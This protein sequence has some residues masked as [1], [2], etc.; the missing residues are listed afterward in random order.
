[1]I[2]SAKCTSLYPPLPVAGQEGFFY[3]ASTFWDE[4][5][6]VSCTPRGLSMV[7]L[8]L[9]KDKVRSEISVCWGPL[10]PRHCAGVY[11]HVDSFQVHNSP[12][13]RL[14]FPSHR[15]NWGSEQWCHWIRFTHSWQS[16]SQ[17]LALPLHHQPPETPCVPRE[18]LDF[19]KEDS[20]KVRCRK[21]LIPARFYLL[22]WLF[23]HLSWSPT[24]ASFPSF[25]RC[26]HLQAQRGS[27]PVSM[28]APVPH[29]FGFPALPRS[30]EAV[31]FIGD[32]SLSACLSQEPVEWEFLANSVH[33]QVWTDGC[34]DE[35]ATFVSGLTHMSTW[36]KMR[37][38]GEGVG[39]KGWGYL[40]GRKNNI[41]IFFSL[42]CI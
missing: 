27:S 19:W 25:L 1:M 20:G 17:P 22:F 13:R 30:P 5:M 31:G 37:R 8:H 18:G 3:C 28:G 7:W 15:G 6:D 32:T 24:P 26:Q 9:A 39:G 12:G 42:H 29:G 35:P 33:W 2:S 14:C 36:P 34:W 21:K 38:S 10:C 41:I 4:R 16:G 23:K 40:T 11:M